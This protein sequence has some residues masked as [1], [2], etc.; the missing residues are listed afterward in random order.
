MGLHHELPIYQDAYRLLGMTT[1]IT[2]N[3]PRDFKRLIG[4]KVREECVE[5]MVLIF[6]ANVARNKTPHIEQ[7]QERVQVIELLLR[8]SKDKRFISVKQYAD[9]IQITDSIGKQSSGW[10]KSS[11]ASPAA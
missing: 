7:L 1:D 3:I 5:A 2:R 10:K 6:R 11:A 4:E 8:M 9:A